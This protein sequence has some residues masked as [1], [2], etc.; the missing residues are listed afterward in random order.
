M[1]LL[2]LKFEKKGIDELKL[3]C[4]KFHHI[5]RDRQKGVA[6]CKA[7]ARQSQEEN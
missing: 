5:Y 6:D 3:H 1:K 4:E 7:T 2:N